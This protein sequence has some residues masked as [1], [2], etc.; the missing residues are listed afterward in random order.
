M[1]GSMFRTSIRDGR[2]NVRKDCHPSVDYFTRGIPPLSCTHAR[3]SSCGRLDRFKEQADSCAVR[4]SVYGS[5][6]VMLPNAFIFNVHVLPI[7]NCWNSETVP[8]EYVSC[9]PVS[10]EKMTVNSSDSLPSL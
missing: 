9:S 8:G 4:L 3:Q 6:L 7:W 5:T 2:E 10:V 1:H